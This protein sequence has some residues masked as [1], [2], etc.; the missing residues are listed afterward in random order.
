M[1]YSPTFAKEVV[2][3]HLRHDN[4]AQPQELVLQFMLS[5]STRPEFR[6]GA[7]A[8]L[9]KRQRQDIRLSPLVAE[10]LTTIVVFLFDRF[11]SQPPAYA[12]I[13]SQSLT[14]EE[15]NNRRLE[16]AFQFEF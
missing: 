10:A 8:I 3:C 12:N 4:P 5:A 13:F 16:T 15:S 11:L 7:D 1:F 2:G 14:L 9:Y 6:C